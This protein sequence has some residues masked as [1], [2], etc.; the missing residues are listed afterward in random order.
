MPFLL[1]YYIGRAN[2]ALV[3]YDEQTLEFIDLVHRNKSILRRICVI[4]SNRSAE[5]IRDLYQDIVCE[6][7]V[8]YP[9]FRRESGERTWVYHVALNT[10]LRQRHRQ[11][12]MPVMVPLDGHVFDTWADEADD[13]M[14]DQ[15][16]ALIERLPDDER[17]LAY[18]Y[19]DNLPMTQI[20]AVLGIGVPTAKRRVKQIKDKLIKLYN[21]EKR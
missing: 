15:L 6:L 14:V 8:G 21:D 7:W 19:I 20:A 1:L 2:Y 13:G 11:R 17:A 9:R 5:D 12:R 18:L 16:Y 10:A 3:K 4:F